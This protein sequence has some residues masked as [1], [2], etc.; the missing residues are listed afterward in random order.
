MCA[1]ER[2][3]S[4]EG[5]GVPGC[6]VVLRQ[7]PLGDGCRETPTERRVLPR[8][9]LAGPC[10]R[11]GGSRHPPRGGQGRLG[12]RRRPGPAGL[13]PGRTPLGAR[14][15]GRGGRG[16]GAGSRPWPLLPWLH[17]GP[18]HTGTQHSYHT[19]AH[20]C[21]LAQPSTGERTLRV[22]VCVQHCGASTVDGWPLKGGGHRYAHT[23]PD[24]TARPSR[25][26]TSTGTAPPLRRA[27]T[28]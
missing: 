23:M 12:G 17:T 2:D 10:I 4:G 24:R 22:G 28:T 1:R 5:E 25:M 15:R 18:P 11:P 16:L 27:S 21:P 3:H 26:S 7:T 6:A 13:Q 19:W 9:K 8:P 20:P 14:G